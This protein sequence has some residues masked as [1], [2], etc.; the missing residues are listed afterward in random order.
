MSR[1]DYERALYSHNVKR[2]VGTDGVV[3]RIGDEGDL[4]NAMGIDIGI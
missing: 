3:T 2:A 4:G 1:N